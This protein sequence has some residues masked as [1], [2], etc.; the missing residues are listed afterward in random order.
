MNNLG[1]ALGTIWMTGMI[2]M[3]GDFRI[4]S[5]PSAY[6]SVTQVMNNRID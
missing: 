6:L 2:V 4:T 1:L 5:V 3:A